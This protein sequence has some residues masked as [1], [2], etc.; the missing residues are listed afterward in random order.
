MTGV[1]VLLGGV[2]LVA[3][4]IMLIDVIGRRKDRRSEHGR[5]A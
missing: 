4:I 2:V 5:P 3:F 1:Y